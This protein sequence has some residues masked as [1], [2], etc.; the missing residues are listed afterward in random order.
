M[1]ST[2]SGGSSAIASSDTSSSV[3]INAAAVG[4]TEEQR[5]L[6]NRRQNILRE[7]VTTE[8]AYVVALRTCLE[9][10]R[11]G[12][13]NPPGDIPVSILVLLPLNAMCLA[14][15]RLRV[16]MPPVAGLVFIF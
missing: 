6:I 4:L 3:G 1:S 8:R 9:T 2:G 5:K 10:F 11:I 7:L 12:T 15:E 14:V 16:K 13:M